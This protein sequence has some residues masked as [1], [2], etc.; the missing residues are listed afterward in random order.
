[1]KKKRST[2][3][4]VIQIAIFLI[5]TMVYAYSS[6][7]LCLFVWS[8]LLIT[9]YNIAYIIKAIT[10]LVFMAYIFYLWCRLGYSVLTTIRI[11]KK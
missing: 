9:S 4:V 11:N 7:L 1:M 3:V 10:T 6:V 5:F 8:E 2:T